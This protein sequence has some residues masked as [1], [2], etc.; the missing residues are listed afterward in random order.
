MIFWFVREGVKQKMSS[1]LQTGG[2]KIAL[3][4]EGAVQEERSGWGIPPLLAHVCLR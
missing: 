3:G 2:Q 1:G 4:V